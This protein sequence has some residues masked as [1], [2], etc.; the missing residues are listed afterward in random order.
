MEYRPNDWTPISVEM[1]RLMADAD[2]FFGERPTVGKDTLGDRYTEMEYV[3]S[4]EEK[5]SEPGWQNVTDYFIDSAGRHWWR[6][7]C[8]FVDPYGE[9]VFAPSSQK[10]FGHSVDAWEK[11]R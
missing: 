3:G 6:Q 4:E 9:L 10:H 11:Q 7:R 2:G 5:S 1:R 8:F